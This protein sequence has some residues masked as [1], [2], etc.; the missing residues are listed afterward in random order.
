MFINWLV[1]EPKGLRNFAS[2]F[3]G[4]GFFRLF[5][6]FFTRF[7]RE[8]YRLLSLDT[9]A[10]GLFAGLVA[11]GILKKYP[12]VVPRTALFMCPVIFYLTVKAVEALSK[13]HHNVFRTAMG[14]F[15]AFLIFQP[16]F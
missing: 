1:T 15:M 6:G 5:Y 12:F 14:I 16:L 4:F 3:F 7:K 9:V 2:V 8:Q 13:I 11:L 10:F